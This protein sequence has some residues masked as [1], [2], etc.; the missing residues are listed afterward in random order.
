M[1]SQ[2]H[3]NATVLSNLL[4]PENTVKLLGPDLSS[5]A[6][7]M[8][9]VGNDIPIQVILDVGALIVDLENDEVAR[10]WLEMTPHSGK[11]AVIFLSKEDDILVMDRNGFVEPFLTSSFVA[12]TD[13]CLVF[14]DEAHTR[15]IDLNYLITTG[16]QRCLVRS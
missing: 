11:E 3:T 8:A 14:L 13:A 16:P 10:R 4:R 1:P 6:L 2:L 5:E 7:L 12:N 9:V 15:G